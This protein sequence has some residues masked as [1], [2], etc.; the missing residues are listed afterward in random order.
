[1][2]VRISQGKFQVI[3]KKNK[4][5]RESKHLCGSENFK[6]ITVYTVSKQNGS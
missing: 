3:G 4:Q 1:M 6:D 2:R 5:T